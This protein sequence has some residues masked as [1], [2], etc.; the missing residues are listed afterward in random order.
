MKD[1]II[2]VT[3]ILIYS[4]ITTPIFKQN[5]KISLNSLENRINIVVAEDIWDY[6]SRFSL[7]TN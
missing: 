6:L 4:F 2:L 5:D 1:K 7:N 3:I